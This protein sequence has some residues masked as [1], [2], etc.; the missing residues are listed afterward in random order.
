MTF[1]F[2]VVH[3]LLH[4]QISQVLSLCYAIPI[5]LLLSQDSGLVCFYLILLP[6]TAAHP[7]LLHYSQQPSYGNSQ[8]APLLTI[9]L[10]KCG[11]YTQW[12]FT[13]P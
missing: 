6:D 5:S 1:P 8:D 12:N 3:D 2:L 13:Q 9:G 4:V 11:I 10:S 7:C